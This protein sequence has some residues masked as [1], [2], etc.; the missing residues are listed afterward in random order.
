M[1]AFIA[2]ATLVGI[3]CLTAVDAGGPPRKE[4]IPK[5]IKTLQTSPTAKARV[6]AAEDIGYR[7]AIRASDVD[8]AIDPLLKS[9]K[10]DKDA[11]VRVT[12]AKSL[13]NI[14]T[15]AEKCVAGLTD[16]LKDSSPLVKMAAA[17]ALGQFG[18]EAKSAL[19]GLMEL[20]KMKDSKDD[21]KISQFAAAAAKSIVG[22]EK[23][24]K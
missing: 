3:V 7:G 12:C 16:A 1:R 23:K 9:L 10:S 11:E 6:Q 24:K 21:K 5:F 13:G 8:S 20:A 15:N 22:T 18:P 17:Q 19:P 2:L 4:D 14:G